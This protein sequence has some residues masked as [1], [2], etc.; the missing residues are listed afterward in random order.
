MR[1]TSY[2]QFLEILPRYHKTP[3]DTDEVSA[4]LADLF[5]D[6]PDLRGTSA[7]IFILHRRPVL[8]NL[9]DSPA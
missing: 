2:R 7:A 5:K 1:L 4:Q 9:F 3:T 8:D 6:A